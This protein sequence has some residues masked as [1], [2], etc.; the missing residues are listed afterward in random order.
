MASSS[1]TQFMV[2]MYHLE[3]VREKDIPYKKIHKIEDAAEVFH[4][5]LDSSHVEKMAVIH[6]NSSGEMIGAEVIAVG[7]L[8]TVSA[9][10]SDLFKGAIKNNAASIFMAHNHPTGSVKASVPDFLFTEK[11]LAA[12]EIMGIRVDDHLVIVP[13]KHYSLREHADEMQDAVRNGRHPLAG[14]LSDGSEGAQKLPWKR[15]LNDWSLTF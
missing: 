12:S 13:G 2:P 4:S 7:S 11:V 10:M 1:I 6:C 3:L 15:G 14:L 8:E 9:D 5:M